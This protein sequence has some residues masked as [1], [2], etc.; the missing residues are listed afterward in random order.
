MMSSSSRDDAA[1]DFDGPSSPIRDGW[2]GREIRPPEED[3]PAGTAQAGEGS[4]TSSVGGRSAGKETWMDFLKSAPPGGANDD[5]EPAESPAVDGPLLGVRK[6]PLSEAIEAGSTASRTDTT[7]LAPTRAASSQHPTGRRR[8][9]G[10]VSGATGSC[11]SRLRSDLLL[12]A[13]ETG[14]RG[15]ST[16]H[17]SPLRPVSTAESDQSE[18]GPHYE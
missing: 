6:R 8:P 1:A 18:G 10:D 13:V 14:E 7:V 17:H 12:D 5:E 2:T 16:H 15:T 11:P 3:T 9:I 4:R